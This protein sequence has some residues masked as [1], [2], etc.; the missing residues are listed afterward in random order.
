[1]GDLKPRTV[2][3]VAL[4]ETIPSVLLGVIDVLSTAGIAWDTLSGSGAGRPLFR[5]MLIGSNVD[6]IRV[7]NG[8]VIQPHATYAQVESTD[9]VFIPPLWMTAK[10]DR[11]LRHHDLFAWL[12]RMSEKGALLTSVCNGSL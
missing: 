9:I 4:P 6:P 7:A 1:M 2:C 8:V 3:L 11:Y 5:P 12:M 10:D